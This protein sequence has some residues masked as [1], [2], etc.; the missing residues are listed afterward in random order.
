MLQDLIKMPGQTFQIQRLAVRF[1]TIT[2][3]HLTGKSLQDPAGQAGC[4]HFQIAVYKN[5]QGRHLSLAIFRKHYPECACL[6]HTLN[7]RCPYS[8]SAN[9]S[10]K[11]CCRAA[12]Q[13]LRS[14]QRVRE[15][16]RAAPHRACICVCSDT[17]SA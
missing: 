8:N 9:R 5:S 16:V 15:S 6:Q 12:S 2:A 10:S 17:A 1:T 4:E 11:P 13:I 3:T 7:G 14:S